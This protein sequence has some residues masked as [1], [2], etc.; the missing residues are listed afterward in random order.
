MSYQNYVVAV[1]KAKKCRYYTVMDG[2]SEL[3]IKKAEEM[4]GLKFSQQLTEYYTKYNY[5]SF[6][7]N[8]IFG[9][10]P[11]DDSGILEGNSVLYALN[12][13]AEYGLKKEWIPIY[14]YGDG[15]LAYLD[16]S[17]LNDCNEP[18]VLRAYYDGTKYI[19][20]RIVSDDFADF[21]LALVDESNLEY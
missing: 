5:M 9:I 13:R 21:L 14:T 7:G 17:V 10:D 8:E 6:E 16:Y 2:V 15:M 3:V 11:D 1:E 18:R 12:D 19:V 20:D 4:L